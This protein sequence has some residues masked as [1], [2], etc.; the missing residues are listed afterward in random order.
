M[1]IVISPDSFK[2]SLTAMEAARKIAAGIK[3]VSPMIETVLLPV[4]DGGEGTLEPL[5]MATNG[6]M[7]YVD[8]HDPIGSPIR[9]EYGVLR[10]RRNM[11]H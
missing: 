9:V 7:V 4:A 8:V 5:I 10:R 3:E 1:K 11:C 2:G 6:H